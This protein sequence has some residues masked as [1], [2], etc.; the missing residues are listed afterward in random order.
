MRRRGASASAANA[1]VNVNEDVV[2]PVRGITKALATG[3]KL[4]KRILKV[5][6]TNSAAQATQNLQNSLEQT[7]LAINSAY[8]DNVKSCGEPFTKALV[9]DRRFRRSH[10]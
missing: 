6:L 10:G 7:A 2:A 8:G 5:V 4:T 9:E 1:D 3:C